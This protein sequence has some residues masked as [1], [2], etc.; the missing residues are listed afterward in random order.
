MQDV[1]KGVTQLS[2]VL[3]MGYSSDC[4]DGKVEIAGQIHVFRQIKQ[5]TLNRRYEILLVIPLDKSKLPQVFETGNDIDKDYIHRYEDGK[6]CLATDIDMVEAFVR[7]DSLVTWMK[8]FVEPYFVSYEYYR[9]YGEFPSGDREHGEKGILHSYAEIFTTDDIAAWHII[10]YISNG[11][12]RGHH[13]CP[14]GSGEKLRKCHGEEIMRF[15]N[16]Q[17]LLSQT[18]KDYSSIL[19]RIRKDVARQYQNSNSRK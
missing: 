13:Q 4:V 5:F 8:D 12:Y 7:N 3:D 17:Q 18:K 1:T 10:E 15:I 2:S 11:V 9:R 16:N 14:C 19:E 6:L